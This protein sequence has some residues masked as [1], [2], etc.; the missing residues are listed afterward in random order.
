[1]GRNNK[2]KM[3]KSVNTVRHATF[4]LKM[5]MITRDSNIKKQRR[6]PWIV[7]DSVNDAQ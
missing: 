7:V 3:T 4:L 2:E 5:L 1:M 6:P